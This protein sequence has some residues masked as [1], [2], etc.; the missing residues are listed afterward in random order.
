[1]ARQRRPLIAAVLLGTVLAWAPVMAATTEDITV[2]QQ[3]ISDGNATYDYLSS[4]SVDNLGE[5]VSHPISTHRRTG[6]TCGLWGTWQLHSAN[7]DGER[8]YV[9]SIFD[10]CNSDQQVFPTNITCA[11][12]GTTGS[13]KAPSFCETVDPGHIPV[14]LAPQ[15]CMA[16][17]DQYILLDA[18]LNPSTY[19][20]SKSTTLAATPS[21]VSD[22][23]SFSQLLTERFCT[24]ILTWSVVGWT[25]KW[26][27]GATQAVPG[28]GHATPTVT[29]TLAPDPTQSG[30]TIS[31][32][33]VVAHLHIHGRALDFN[34]NGDIVA[35]SR[36]AFVDISNKATA[37]ST[38]SAP[39][40]TAP[41]LQVGGIAVDQSADGSMPAPAPGAPAA[42]HV[43]T[44][45]G[46][47]LDL[48]P[49][50]VVITPG[51]ESIGGV[52]MG[53]ATTTTTSW[54]YGG[55]WTDAPPGEGTAPG[56]TGTPADPV[57]L[58]WNSAEPLGAQ[59]QP[60]DVEV[61]LTV[62]AH[63]VWPDGHA[64]DETLT[65]NVSV[66]IYFIGLNFEG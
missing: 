30:A 45:R 57:Q 2:D 33:T 61:P 29:H 35:V 19:D 24:D 26:Q 22:S 37:A 59:D 3:T 55:G 6:P 63:T 18:A 1:M 23:Q 25:F 66:T 34:A 58:Q 4:G 17:A 40:Y 44:I 50:V 47:L 8:R 7:R 42:V 41:Q 51:V 38:G 48:Y 64:E 14:G 60:V 10:G 54:R 11:N 43:A 36:D 16:G 49:R 46:R 21:F 13:Q 52:P 56:A 27:D 15:D 12:D 39:V 32:V 65:A 53:A 28:S 31:D 62:H 5:K 20:P 9:V